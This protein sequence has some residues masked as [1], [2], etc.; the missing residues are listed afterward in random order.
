MSALGSLVGQAAIV[1]F[2]KRLQNQASKKLVLR[3]FFRATFVAEPRK[4]IL[5]NDPGQSPAPPL[6]ICS[7]Y[8]YV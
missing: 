3:E 7:S 6:A 2:K 4:N 8:S 1:G 5:R